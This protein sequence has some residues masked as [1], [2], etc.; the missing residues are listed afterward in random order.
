MGDKR[1]S[2]RRHTKYLLTPRYVKS[3]FSLSPFEL[4]SFPSFVVFILSSIESSSSKF[5]MYIFWTIPRIRNIYTWIYFPCFIYDLDDEI[6]DIYLKIIILTQYVFTLYPHLCV[7][8]RQTMT[9][10]ATKWYETTLIYCFKKYIIVLIHHADISM[11]PLW[12]DDM[13]YGL[14]M[15]E[16]FDF[17]L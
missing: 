10:A 8:T 15:C 12:A 5:I 17:Q 1:K 14:L 13:F 16:G 2:I 4:F 9:A 11:I 6:F 3:I 7:F